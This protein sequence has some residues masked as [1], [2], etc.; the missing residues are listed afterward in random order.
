MLE[1]VIDC[2]ADVFGKSDGAKWVICLGPGRTE[3]LCIGLSGH[4]AKGE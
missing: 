1:Q 2:E 4:D 3:P